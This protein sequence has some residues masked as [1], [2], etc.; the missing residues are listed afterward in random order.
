MFAGC[1]D[2]RSIA[3]PDGVTTIEEMAFYSCNWMNSITIPESV[4]TI[5][6]SSFLDTNLLNIYYG[7]S[8]EQWKNNVAIGDF[9]DTL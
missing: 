5:G 4:T 7:G 8:K 9:N 3:I 2:L 1:D 6:E